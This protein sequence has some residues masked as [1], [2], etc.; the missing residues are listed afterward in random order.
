MHIDCATFLG[1]PTN[2]MDQQV[3]QDIFSMVADSLWWQT[4]SGTLR[5]FH[6]SQQQQGRRDPHNTEEPHPAASHSFHWQ[7]LAI[8]TASWDLGDK[9]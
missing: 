2:L 9:S 1:T 8:A 4:A 5:P 6:T 3:T 7:R